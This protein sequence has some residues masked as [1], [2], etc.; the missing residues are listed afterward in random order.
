MTNEQRNWLTSA[1][2]FGGGFVS[3]FAD[4]CFRADDE[5]FKLIEPVLIQLMEKYPSYSSVPFNRGYN[6]K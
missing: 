5:N 3:S 6:E 2:R 1:M 4:C